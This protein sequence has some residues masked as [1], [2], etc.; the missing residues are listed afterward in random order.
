MTPRQFGAI[1]DGVHD[2]RAAIQAAINQGGTVDLEGLTYAV[3]RSGTAYH[4]L[5][6]AGG[7]QLVNGT[8]RQLPVA[9]S[10]RL[11]KVS[12]WNNTLR[13]LV[14]DGNRAAQT[15]VDEHR[16]GVFVDG[17]NGTLLHRVTAT[18]FT[19][20]GVYFYNAIDSQ[21][22]DCQ[23]HGNDRNGLTF[24]GQVT[25]VTV[26]RGYYRD[27][28]AQQIDSEPGGPLVV[29]GIQ[30]RDVT[31]DAGASTDYAL[32]VSGASSGVPGHHWAIEDC[33]VTGDVF[34][35]WAEDISFA[36]STVIGS[37]TVQRS[38]AR[39]TIR[40]CH[41]ESL[42]IEGTAGS[43]PSCVLVSGCRI[44]NGVSVRGALS[45]RLLGNT[46]V[47]GGVYLRDTVAGRSVDAIIT[48]NELT[49]GGI[50][51]NGAVPGLTNLRNGTSSWT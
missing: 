51:T 18:G 41:L 4:C 13:D 11:L 47:S 46:I 49:A 40:G 21:L 10:V 7:V 33:H 25:G 44:G 34:V 43:G 42:L 16:A 15:G 2:D 19:G 23:C 28:G 38:S 29:S 48:D 1:A 36:F 3:G 35:V 22:I 17:G 27:N 50:V 12:G 9:P 32:T 20:D 30:L 24:G 45:C 39:V 37:V 6:L 5:L 26:E 31:I 8:L 14:L